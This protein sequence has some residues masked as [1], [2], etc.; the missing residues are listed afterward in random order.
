M[1]GQTVEIGGT[2]FMITSMQVCGGEGGPVSMELFLKSVGPI[3]NFNTA[4]VD[5]NA[6]VTVS[7]SAVKS[8]AEECDIRGIDFDFVDLKL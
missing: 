3:D 2:R 6:T 8:V 5:E 4:V 1:T 7:K